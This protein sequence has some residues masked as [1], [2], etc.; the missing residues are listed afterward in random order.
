[1]VAF[2]GRYMIA[3]QQ[4]NRLSG[5]TADAA[6]LLDQSIGAFNVYRADVVDLLDQTIAAAPKMAMG[7]I[8]KAYVYGLATEPDATVAARDTLA[9]VRQM[10]LDDRESSHVVALQLLL[11][12]RWTA[13][14]LHLD[15][16][17]ADYPL[18]MIA[19]QAGHLMDFYRANARNLRDRIAR[20][21][22]HWSPAIP[23]HSVVRGMYAFG[24]EECGDYSH[25]EE[26]GRSA[27][28]VDPS[29]CWAHHAVAHVME[30]QGRA[31]D[32]IGWM[33]AREPFWAGDSNAFKIHLWWHRALCHLEL[34]Q[35]EAALALYDGPIREQTSRVALD[36]VDASALLW[37]LQ[38]AGCDV[39]DRWQELAS[40][41]DLHAD[42]TSYPFNDW[43]AVM[44]YLGA[45]RSADVDRILAA[46]RRGD[47]AL[48][49]GEWARRVALPLTE[50]FT[51][52][53]NGDYRVAIE[54]LHPCRFIANAFGGSH[55]QRDVI[56]WTLAESALRGGFHGV[57]EAL[58]QERLALKPHSAVNR[59]L[60]ARALE[61]AA[62]TGATG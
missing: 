5:A 34:G 2:E 42:G 41:W 36:M 22:H 21:L 54:K 23:G 26:Q 25:A 10:D 40:C 33:T 19:L 56:D 59:Q 53:C 57:A 14:A 12:G 39:D 7:H 29:D 49:T 44:A 6:A 55:A 4:G 52:F 20:V 58:A 24:L 18:D 45:G 62:S 27:I 13:A 8:T 11:D 31:E 16:H 28:A 17:N 48:E 3:D 60:L 47:P 1:M 46:Q 9:E 15:R 32:G 38:L 61:Q 35:T 30:M 37:R 43:H 51:A 50:G